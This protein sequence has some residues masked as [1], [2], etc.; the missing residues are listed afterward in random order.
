MPTVAMLPFGQIV[1]N[2]TTLT[3]E[4][5]QKA[6]KDLYKNFPILKLIHERE[7]LLRWHPMPDGTRRRTFIGSRK[8]RTR[9]REEKAERKEV[10]REMG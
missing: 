7:G 10:I 8:S 2:M 6:V 9:P 4:A 1:A 3:E 5:G